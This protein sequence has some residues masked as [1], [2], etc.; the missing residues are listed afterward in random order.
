MISPA[1]IRLVMLDR[2]GVINHD[3]PDYIKNVSEWHPIDGSIEAIANLS[4]A[5]FVVCIATN[6]AGI[7]R[8]LI[9]QPDLDGIHQRLIHRVQDAGGM[10]THIAFCP[11]HPDDGCDCRKPAPGMLLAIGDVT[12]MDIKGQPFVGDSAKDVEAAIAAGCSPVIVKTGN[13]I[14]TAA[15]Y[16]DVMTFDKLSDF[17][18]WAV[19]GRP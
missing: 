2:D 17:A 18:E 1:D 15:S 8:G 16:P 12:R 5:G 14:E 7:G 6:Q 11:H 3:S 13:G 9:S 19:A 4:N 10:I